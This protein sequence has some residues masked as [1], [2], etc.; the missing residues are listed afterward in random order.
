M[1]VLSFIHVDHNLQVL[2]PKRNRKITEPLLMRGLNHKH[3]IRMR[4]HFLLRGFNFLVIDYCEKGDLCDYVY[5]NEYLEEDEARKIMLQLVKG[6]RYL[7][8]QGIC[9]RDLKLVRVSHEVFYFLLNATRRT[10]YSSI[11]TSISV[12]VILA[13]VVYSIK[14]RN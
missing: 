13:P 7:H 11:R 8:D 6:V 14:R 2:N 12:L 10:T 3:L 4:E 5:E 1:R 9:H